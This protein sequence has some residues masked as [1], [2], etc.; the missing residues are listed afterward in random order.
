M[1]KLQVTQDEAG[2]LWVRPPGTVT[3]RPVTRE[4]ADLLISDE[5]AGTAF[6]ESIREQGSQ[7]GAGIQKLVGPEYNQAWADQELAR[8]RS[9]QSARSMQSPYA[10]GAG[11]IVPELGLAAATGGSSIPLMIGAEAA[12]GAVRNPENPLAGAALAGGLAAVVPGAAALVRGAPA[13]AGRVGGLLDQLGYGGGPGMSMVAPGARSTAAGRVAA[14]I[15]DD[16]PGAPP[17]P[18]TARV[19]QGTLTPDELRQ[20]GLEVSPGQRMMLEATDQRQFMNAKNRRFVED[21]N[22][23]VP[24]LGGG[25]RQLRDQQEGFL[26]DMIK[27]ELGDMSVANMT[28]ENIGQQL[29]A[30]GKIIG[31]FG[32]VAG[33]VQLADDALVQMDD[34]VGRSNLDYK[35]VIETQVADIKAALERGGGLMQPRDFQQIHS[36]LGKIIAGSHGEGQAGKLAAASDV[37]DFLQQALH[38]QLPEAAKAELSQ[39]RY[40]YRILKTLGNYGV[41]NVR[42]EVNPASFQRY[43]NKRTSQSQWGRAEDTLG[44]TA[45]TVN[46]LLAPTAHT[47][48]TLMR[49]LINT[50]ARVVQ[51]GPGGAVAGAVGAGL[52]GY[53]GQ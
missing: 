50:P 49:G 33:P 37:Q 11:A 21:T 32:E 28:P 36:N 19:M 1:P 42:G 22:Q 3:P 30:Q 4:Q 20:L 14:R 17:A 31:K 29:K 12:L 5:G 45:Y 47:G 46:N 23:D 16:V 34:I 7:I 10:S 13:A 2:Q 48:N 8:S 15:G 35:G 43:W 53:F 27:R 52:V 9:T 38:K 51:A 26:G 39:A 18:G 44:R 25:I 40:R 41:T 6:L 24:G